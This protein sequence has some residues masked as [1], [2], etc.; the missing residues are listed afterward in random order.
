MHHLLLLPLPQPGCR[1]FFPPGKLLVPLLYKFHLQIA[2]PRIRRRN[3]QDIICL[4]LLEHKIYPLKYPDPA[5]NKDPYNILR[6]LQRFRHQDLRSPT[7]S[8]DESFQFHLQKDTDNSGHPPFLHSTGG[9]HKHNIPHDSKHPYLNE[10]Q[11]Q[12]K[13][14]LPD[15][16]FL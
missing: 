14:V 9:N 12:N 4:D 3:H 13:T 16:S 8:Y 6:L 11:N 7:S 1:C 2:L 15:H 5:C 10:F